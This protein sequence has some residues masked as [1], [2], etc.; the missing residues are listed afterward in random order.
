MITLTVSSRELIDLRVESADVPASL[1]AESGGGGA[2]PY[3]NGAYTF[4]PTQSEQTVEIRGMI[5]KQDIVI[6]PIPQNY[7]LIIWNGSVL[8]VS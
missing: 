8:S 1:D 6:E 2:N 4:T 5:A 3:Y 7:G